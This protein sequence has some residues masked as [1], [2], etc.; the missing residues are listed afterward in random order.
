MT[1]THPLALARRARALAMF[2]TGDERTFWV[3]RA[4]THLADARHQRGAA[5]LIGA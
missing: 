4:L 3:R 5:R 1:R 2:S